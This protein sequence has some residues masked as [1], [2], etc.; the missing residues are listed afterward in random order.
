[1]NKWTMNKPKRLQP[2][3]LINDFNWNWTNARP[4]EDGGRDI[5]N[6]E[7]NK[8]TTT[9]AT[10]TTKKGGGARRKVGVALSSK[11]AGHIPKSPDFSQVREHFTTR[12]VLQDHVQI[13]IVLRINTH[14]NDHTSSFAY[15]LLICISAF[16]N[17]RCHTASNR[18]I[19]FFCCRFNELIYG[20]DTISKK[21]TKVTNKFAY[22]N[23][24]N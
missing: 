5:T 10:T 18:P 9:T 16:F 20:S 6:R 14:I 19:Q 21:R 4:M 12:D 24:K 13:G 7:S 11:W 2:N 3:R 22:W 1:M 23:D 15:P 17:R 8:P